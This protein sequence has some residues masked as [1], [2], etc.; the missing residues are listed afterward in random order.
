MAASGTE[1]SEYGSSTQNQKNK[2]MFLK[3]L[4]FIIKLNKALLISR[5]IST[6]L[7][8]NQQHSSFFLY[9][10]YAMRCNAYRYAAIK[11]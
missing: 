11:I 2:I 9:I 5:V 3:Y 8:S 6:C 10:S 1:I 4:K 7:L